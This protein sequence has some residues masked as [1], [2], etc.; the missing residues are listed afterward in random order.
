VETTASDFF[1]L[2]LNVLI[3]PNGIIRIEHAL[4]HWTGQAI[5]LPE[6]NARHFILTNLQSRIDTPNPIDIAQED[7]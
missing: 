2:G 7:S 3:R 1:L 5:A 4:P 6:L